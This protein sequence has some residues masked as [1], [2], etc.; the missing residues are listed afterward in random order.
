MG[1]CLAAQAGNGSDAFAGRRTEI[2]SPSQRSR[3]AAA[4]AVTRPCYPPSEQAQW[5]G[6]AATRPQTIRAMTMLLVCQCAISPHGPRHFAG[7]IMDEVQ[8]CFTVKHCLAPTGSSRNG[9]ADRLRPGRRGG[10]VAAPPRHAR[11]VS[12]T[13]KG[14]RPLLLSPT[15]PIS[16][17][18]SRRTP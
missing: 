10:L 16:Q 6:P 15:I 11:C 13:K 3:L 4:R 5:S 12:S 1:L 2:S 17:A 7:L 14:P 8:G 18:A 9:H